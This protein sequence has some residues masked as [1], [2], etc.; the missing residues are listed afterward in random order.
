MRVNIYRKQYMESKGGMKILF[1]W[2]ANVIC[3]SRQAFL[4]YTY[5]ED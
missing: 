3:P 4:L 1:G 2:S 5:Y